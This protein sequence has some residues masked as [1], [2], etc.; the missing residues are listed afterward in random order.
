MLA[1][2]VC[3]LG[4]ARLEGFLHVSCGGGE[5]A[6][7]FTGLQKW[8]LALDLWHRHGSIESLEAE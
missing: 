2:T 3:A 8:A 4:F 7:Q 1:V 5:I 6:N